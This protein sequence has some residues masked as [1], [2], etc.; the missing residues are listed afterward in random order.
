MTLVTAIND[1]QLWQDALEQNTLPTISDK[2][3]VVENDQ[4]YCISSPLTFDDIENL[5]SLSER[6]VIT[7]I[8]PDIRIA[9][10]LD[11][12]KELEEALTLWKDETLQLLAI[13][14]KQRRKIVLLNLE[15]LTQLTRQ[16]LLNLQKIGWPLTSSV[17][18][19][20]SSTF[21]VIAAQS[22]SQSEELCDLAALLFV[23]SYNLSSKPLK[24]NLSETLFQCRQSSSVIRGRITEQQDS[25][26]REKLLLD[27]LFSVQEQL[28]ASY[29][30]AQKLRKTKELL[31]RENKAYNRELTAL[32]QA[33]TLGQEK[34]DTLLRQLEQ[35]QSSMSWKI[36]KPL[37]AMKRNAASGSEKQLMKENIEMLS[38]TKFFDENWYLEVNS[39][40]RKS[41]MKAAEH[42]LL[43]GAREGRNP[44]KEFDSDWYLKK[45]SDVAESGLNPLVHF[46]KY[47]QKEK[48]KPSPQC[49]N[50]SRPL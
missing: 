45:Y 49:T 19:V 10:F 47:G 50:K 38:R 8:S 17:A 48:R 26:A 25:H 14:K 5:I 39:D 46:L 33:T 35:I 32:H 37:R 7:Y 29:V 3:E 34:I 2:S 21:R 30:G 42:Y 40:V 31:S 11:E 28:E 41:G 1:H 15:Q 24:L 6:L 13:H 20:P 36:T 22:L 4:P 44:S 43:F 23:S 9:E 27:Q 16:S 12:G 18:Q